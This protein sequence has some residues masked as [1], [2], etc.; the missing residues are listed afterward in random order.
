MQQNHTIKPR[1]LLPENYVKGRFEFFFLNLKKQSQWDKNQI[2]NILWIHV[3]N[4]WTEKY[5]SDSK[6][7][8]FGNTR[9]TPF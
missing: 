2:K 8:N 1:V 4:Y 5:P 3:F 9:Q 6:F 7:W